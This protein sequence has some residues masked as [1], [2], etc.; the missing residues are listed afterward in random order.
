VSVKI[1]KFKRKHFV[2]PYCAEKEKKKA[3]SRNLTA[4]KQNNLSMVV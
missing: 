3:A 4:N 2:C 1:S